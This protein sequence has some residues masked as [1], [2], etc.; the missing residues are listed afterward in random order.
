MNLRSALLLLV[1]LV[2]LAFAP[3]CDETTSRDVQA[4][5]VGGET[6][7][8]LLHLVER[9]IHLRIQNQLIEVPPDPIH[10]RLLGMID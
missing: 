4:A 6:T 2:A 1:A 5:K 7:V 10:A 3:G 8:R 9:E